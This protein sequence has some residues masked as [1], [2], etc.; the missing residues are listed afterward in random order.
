MDRIA[1][2]AGVSRATVYVYFDSKEALF[3]AVAN[4]A[5]GRFVEETHGLAV[6]FTG[7]TEALLTQV[8]TQLY[9]MMQSPRNSVI[10]RILISEGR[11]QP[12]L[13]AR[14]HSAVLSRGQKALTHILARGVARKEVRPG[15]AA[16][17]PQI[18][19][20]PAIFFL[21][22]TMVFHEVAPM[23]P[24][25]FLRAHLDLVMRGISVP[26]SVPS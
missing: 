9:A 24:D 3:D 26:P 22:N 19:V 8:F 5:M 2:G 15:A 10:M 4:H 16:A 6:D 23:D 18:L 11:Q 13:V 17:T 25:T 20:A 14:Y 12:E 7:T 21:I 1:R